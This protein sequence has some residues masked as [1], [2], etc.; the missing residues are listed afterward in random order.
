M[1]VCVS[2]GE[3]W[4]LADA[5]AGVADLCTGLRPGLSPSPSVGCLC[6][7]AGMVDCM[8]N[9]SVSFYTVRE[10]VLHYVDQGNGRLSS[11]RAP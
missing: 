9:L 11:L 1:F 3:A 2:L 6:V 4:W 5:G 8:Q 7:D 10:S